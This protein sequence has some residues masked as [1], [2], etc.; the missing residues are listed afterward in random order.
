MSDQ[1]LQ[2][3]ILLETEIEQQLQQEQQKADAWLAVARQGVLQEFAQSRAELAEK[4]RR[5]LQ[6]AERQLE[7]QAEMLLQEEQKYA[8]RLKDLDEQRLLE[9]LRRHIR[10]ILPG[11]SNDHQDG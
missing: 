11:Q 7:L 6:Q 3:V 5:E 8:R 2:A 4:K 1:I 9:M 10:S